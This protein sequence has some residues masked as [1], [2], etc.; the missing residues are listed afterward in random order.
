MKY[1]GLINTEQ[2]VLPLG[3]VCQEWS[4]GCGLFALEIPLWISQCEKMLPF[5]PT[6]NSWLEE[7]R[8][9]FLTEQTVS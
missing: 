5:F 7:I 2:C 1:K 3:A 4:P 8:L 9:A 6:E